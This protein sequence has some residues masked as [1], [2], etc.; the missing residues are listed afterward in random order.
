M[1]VNGISGLADATLPMKVMMAD[2]YSESK[3]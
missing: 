2:K 3:E 1:Y